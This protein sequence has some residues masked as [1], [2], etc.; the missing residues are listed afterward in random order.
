MDGMY[1]RLKRS[2]LDPIGDQLVVENFDSLVR[3]L[4][5]V[6]TDTQISQIKSLMS[7]IK[8]SEHK[9]ENQINEAKIKTSKSKD[10]QTD[11]PKAE[12]DKSTEKIEP[13][14][15]ESK[16]QKT[17]TKT[18]SDS[19]KSQKETTGDKKSNAAMDFEA[20]EKAVPGRHVLLLTKRMDVYRNNLRREQF[21]K[22]ISQRRAIYLSQ[23]TGEMD[24]LYEVKV[25]DRQ[26]DFIDS[27][28]KVSQITDDY[29]VIL[30]NLEEYVIPG[31]A[32]IDDSDN[33]SVDSNHP[34]NP[35]NSYPEDDSD[36]EQSHGAEFTS[37]SALSDDEY[38]ED[39]SRKRPTRFK[40]ELEDEFEF[41]QERSSEN[42][43]EEFSEDEKRNQKIRD[44]FSKL[45]KKEEKR[46]R[47]H[48]EFEGVDFDA[49]K[50]TIYKNVDF[51]RL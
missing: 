6:K 19:N 33:E 4:K 17:E 23:D 51:N 20:L 26:T 9:D 8:I 40:M 49:L 48:N 42:E 37:R 32:E 39:K 3:T 35:D 46:K 50:E 11:S 15:S 45:S 16:D 38:S 28:P 44:L 13:L 12:H 7:D 27:L 36:S 43:E 5:R 24:N 41:D 31:E 1:I 18:K 25:V 29:L 2:T 14:K 22:E 30:P 47:K 21:N 34:E 10:Q